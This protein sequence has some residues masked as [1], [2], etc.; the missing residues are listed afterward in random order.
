MKIFFKFFSNIN[1]KN[2]TSWHLFVMFDCDFV[3]FP[4]AILAQVWY[5]IVWIP[6]LCHLYYFAFA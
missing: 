3:T 2:K 6:D 5:L 4:C 1:V